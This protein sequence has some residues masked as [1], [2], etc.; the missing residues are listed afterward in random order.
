MQRQMLLLT[1]SLRRSRSLLGRAISRI[2]L[3]ELER[4]LRCSSRV[5]NK[6][7]ENPARLSRVVTLTSQNHPLFRSSACAASL[8]PASTRVLSEGA[9]HRGAARNFSLS[10]RSHPKGRSPINP[11]HAV[12][13]FHGRSHKPRRELFPGRK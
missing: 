9:R 12:G 8:F 7:A 6:S 10:I 3:I 1:S 5:H 2:S 4:E 11:A 13:I